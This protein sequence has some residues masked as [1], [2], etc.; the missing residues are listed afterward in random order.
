MRIIAAILILLFAGCSSSSDSLT[1]CYSTSQFRKFS[2][3]SFSSYIMNVRAD[4]MS[5]GDVYIQTPY[6]NLRFEK[7]LEGF[8]ASYTLAFVVRDVH[9]DIVQTKEVERPI[10]VKTYEETISRRFDSYLQSLI[11]VPGDYTI[12]I[13][14][15]DNLSRLRYKL[16]E[17]ITAKNYANEKNFTSSVLFLNT[18]LSNE[19]GITIR[20]IL[21]ASLSLLTDSVGMFQ[22][23]Y[24]LQQ[25]DTIQ[26]TESYRTSRADALEGRS[27]SYMQPPYRIG[28]DDCERSL[29]S[30]YY[31]QD[32]IFIAG[33]SGTLQLIQFYTLPMV[34]GTAIDRV[35]KIKRKEMLDSSV[36]TLNVFRRD[37][38]F[39][40]S[41]SVNE[42][43]S[44]MRY[45]MRQEEYDSL[46]HREK[47]E[48][49]A[50]MNTFWENRG[51]FV[52]RTEFERKV[53]E[54]N[55]LFTSCID[56]SR[57]AMGIVYILCGTP[58]YIDCRGTYIE[59]WV[60]NI[61]DRAFSIQFRRVSE[62]SQLYEM[63]PFSVNEAVWQYFVDRWRRKT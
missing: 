35:V 60:Y 51:G 19:H 44:A 13:I 31:K 2:L 16:K 45:I 50:F 7:V 58:D 56:G 61:G 4:N 20:P 11:L 27:I 40:T 1:D 42:V 55:G 38:R 63:T 36:T 28:L 46:M 30:V 59:T 23:L 49:N 8:K 6:T 26:I 39:L 37:S 41:L 14:S 24:H 52:R 9:N 43:T 21:P 33:K 54:A 53:A 15:T 5:R 3:P 12:E 57:T 29:D 32:S 34:G 48:Q 10:S 18:M 17:K 22:E 25:G 62:R 47:E